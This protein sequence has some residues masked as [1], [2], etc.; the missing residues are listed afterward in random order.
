[1]DEGAEQFDAIWQSHIGYFVE[2]VTATAEGNEEGKE[3][4]LAELEEY[5]VEQAKFFDKATEGRLSEE[6]VVEGLDVHV[7]QLIGAF[8][9]YVEGDLETAYEW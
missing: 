2:Y 5:K 9:A 1:G 6:A 3:Q 4:A 7:D 8:D